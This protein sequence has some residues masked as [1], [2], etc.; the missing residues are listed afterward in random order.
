MSVH[1][2]WTFNNRRDRIH[3]VSRTHLSFVVHLSNVSCEVDFIQSKITHFVHDKLWKIFFV[4]LTHEL[5]LLVVFFLRKTN[6]SQKQLKI[7]NAWF[8][9]KFKFCTHI[10]RELNAFIQRPFSEQHK[11]EFLVWE[12]LSNWFVVS[13]KNNLLVEE[14]LGV[15]L[16]VSF[17][18]FFSLVLLHV[19]LSYCF[20]DFKK[21]RLNSWLFF[22]IVI[23][24]D[25]WMNILIAYSENPQP[26]VF[27]VCFI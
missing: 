15:K 4:L 3:S 27:K 14:T 2:I 21:R 25:L 16:L 22:I 20:V 23:I 10:V 11:S 26:K 7:L 5:V 17:W 8:S 12:D 1:N 13:F 18:F 6:F 24:S 19:C 9:P